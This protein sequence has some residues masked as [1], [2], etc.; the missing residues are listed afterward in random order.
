MTTGKPSD[1]RKF[2]RD[3]DSE[4]ERTAP[5]AVNE[6]WLTRDDIQDF[7]KIGGDILKRTMASG[8]DIVKEV[9][10][11]LPKEASQLLAKGKDEVLRGI[12]KEV[13]QSVLSAAVDKF[14]ATVRE[15]KLEVSIRIRR[16][17]DSERKQAEARQ[18]R[19]QDR[20]QDEGYNAP[21]E[22]K[23]K[24]RREK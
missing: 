24:H 13:A 19:N 14:F 9:K 11:G 7:A 22:H 15:H 8:M 12:S 16:N 4:P 17:E 23:P 10:D 21:S 18:K 5:A 1:S 3:S 6:R 2:G 20:G